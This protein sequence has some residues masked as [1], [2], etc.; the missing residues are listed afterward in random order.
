[1][2][3]ENTDP[4]EH[5]PFSVVCPCCSTALGVGWND[6]PSPIIHLN[7]GGEKEEGWWFLC[8]Q[9]NYRWWYQ[10]AYIPAPGE[11]HAHPALETIKNLLSQFS[12]DHQNTDNLHLSHSRANASGT[13]SD[14]L[15]DLDKRAR[16]A[17]Q[18][19]N[20]NNPLYDP[21]QIAE[22]TRKTGFTFF[23]K[24]HA[25]SNRKESPQTGASKTA[26]VSAKEPPNK[27][28]YRRV[29][30]AEFTAPQPQKQL[31]RPVTKT[32][33]WNIFRSARPAKTAAMDNQANS[34]DGHDKTLN[35]TPNQHNAATANR[36]YSPLETFPTVKQPLHLQAVSF[37]MDYHPLTKDV[38]HGAAQLLSSL[39]RMEPSA[40]EVIPEDPPQ[41]AQ[42]E[43]STTP[44][45]PSFLHESEPTPW[46]N[47][48]PSS[49]TVSDFT[50]TN[51]PFVP[52]FAPA[53][54]DQAT[55]P[56]LIPAEEV[57]MLPSHSTVEPILAKNVA[58][59]VYDEK[60]EADEMTA[61]SNARQ[62]TVL[63]PD[64]SEIME[65][66]LSQN[67]TAATEVCASKPAEVEVES[68]PPVS[69]SAEVSTKQELP[70]TDPAESTEPE[71]NA[72]QG[73]EF[74]TS[75]KAD[76]IAED[77]TPAK[78]S[79]REPFFRFFSKK[80]V[81][82]SHSQHKRTDSP[83]SYSATEASASNL[84][85]HTE[86]TNAASEHTNLTPTPHNTT[87]SFLLVS[88]PITMDP[89]TSV[90]ARKEAFIQ[91]H[92]LANQ[93]SHQPKNQSH[94]PVA[95]QDPYAFTMSECVAHLPVTTP[96]LL[97]HTPAKP[98]RPDFIP[99]LSLRHFHFTNLLRTRK[100]PRPSITWKANA[101]S[102]A[103]PALSSITA[104]RSEQEEI[105]PQMDHI[106]E[107]LQKNIELC[108]PKL[109][110]DLSGSFS[111]TTPN[112]FH[113]ANT[114]SEEPSDYPPE[115]EFL[116][117]EQS[118]RIQETLKNHFHSHIHSKLEKEYAALEPHDPI[119]HIAFEDMQEKAIVL[120]PIMPSLHPVNNIDPIEMPKLKHSSSE[121]KSKHP[122]H[123]TSPQ[124]PVKKNLPYKMKILGS[125]FG[126]TCLVCG[127]TVLY[128]DTGI[129]YWRKISF[130]PKR[131][132]IPVSISLENVTY[133]VSPYGSKIELS[134]MGEIF[135]SYT[136]SGKILP[137][138]FTVF[139]N[140]GSKEPLY[141]WT[142]YH[143][144]THI[145]P[146]ERVLFRMLKKLDIPCNTDLR[147]EAE[148]ES[149]FARGERNKS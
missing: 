145:L 92:R 108:A 57:V 5:T 124:Q 100:K 24:K 98:R 115:E 56:R 32:T 97:E 19:A 29:L 116:A 146:K 87:T 73:D 46:E 51:T 126:I 70:N 123:K 120:P 58:E 91:Q 82:P 15:H 23:P 79:H 84:Q 17:D 75:D 68:A 86:E 72:E 35:A 83:V 49:A 25:K 47:A 1:M 76:H 39:H 117:P 64:I 61:E 9:C 11:T 12:S 99:K 45:F 109:S 66:I 144:T 80:W 85:H 81:G 31:S 107:T 7:E 10:R 67:M 53:F 62:D 136:T 34:A 14:I 135:N 102:A 28:S 147:V 125:L 114:H 3:S 129:D 69:E 133:T 26:P 130:M 95:T 38:T 59:E 36:S 149:P 119:I 104:S 138:R 33:R 52:P 112:N 131:N 78:K 20:P 60:A 142:Y 43:S 48:L 40:S 50:P 96:L 4:I 93:P 141:A 77:T 63:S 122:K 6:L 44:D 89:K 118:V 27:Y 37:H 134:I 106:E 127:I 143:F 65:P 2:R 42:Q 88:S 140:D 71:K 90:Q 113:I 74:H 132:A 137:I 128:Q 105:A 111:E 139:K 41:M 121:K 55:A 21:R 101:L 94:Q 148:F 30:P 110:D 8:S 54:L 16:K 103:S 13:E 18:K 22:P